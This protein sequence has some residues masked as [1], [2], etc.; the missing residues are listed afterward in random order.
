MKLGKMYCDYKLQTRDTQKSIQVEEALVDPS[1]SHC[2]AP[3][4]WLQR[5]RSPTARLPTGYYTEHTVHVPPP[6]RQ[7]ALISSSTS[8]TGRVYGTPTAATTP[9]GRSGSTITGTEMHNA[10]R[11][12]PLVM[13]ILGMPTPVVVN[14]DFVE[15]S[16][17]GFLCS[18]DGGSVEGANLDLRIGMEA[19]EQCPL[20]HELRPGGLLAQQSLQSLKAEGLIQC[21]LAESPMARRPWTRMKTMFIDELQRGPPQREYVGFNPRNSRQWRF[22]Q[23]AKEF[24][25]GIFRETTRTKDLIEGLHSHSSY[26]R[27]PQQAVPEVRHMAPGP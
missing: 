20:L 17:W 9:S 25:M 22:S 6:V 2:I 23:H 13:Y 7:D 4:S 1:R 14:V 19:I 27:S 15:E 21:D 24:R 5:L 11:A 16:E 12:G 3:L 26:Q 8:M 18:D 10:V